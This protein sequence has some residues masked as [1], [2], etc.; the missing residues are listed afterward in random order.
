MN[1]WSKHSQFTSENAIIVYLFLAKILFHLLHPEYGYFRDEFFYIAVSDQ[2]S[3]A[4]L[5]V[6]PL[7]PLFL[8]FITSIFGYSIK[9]LH[10]AS[11]LCSAISLLLAC[12][13]TRELGGKKYAVLLT[14]LFVF[15]SGFMIF[16][17]IF[18]YDSLDFL[19][20]V[21]A[22]YLLV[23]IVKTDNQN[24]WLW[25]GLVL[26]LGIL[27][28]L[29]TLAFGLALFM[30]LWLVPQR[31]YFKQKWIWLAGIFALLFSIPFV[32]WQI[33]NDW[34]FIGVAAGYSGGIAYIASFPEFLWS[35]ILP[36][37][38]FSFPVW[39]AGL[40]LLLF[41]NKWKQ[42]RLFGFMYVFLFFLFFFMF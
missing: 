8:K 34:Y 14:G 41:S 26:G 29:S 42:Y 2:Y 33:N 31:E 36:N 24:L 1:Q 28:K 27:N 32:I 4:N 18:T 10:F 37:N 12:L 9:A 6:L 7:S 22:I 16:G 20:S 30:C 35:Q 11:G 15:F 5:D 38:I 40:G 13:I 25:V 17:A 19:I 39:A 21:T 23:K 3:F